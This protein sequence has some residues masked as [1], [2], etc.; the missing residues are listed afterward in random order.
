MKLLANKQQQSYEKKMT[1]IFVKKGFKIN[2]LKKKTISQ[3][4]T[5]VKI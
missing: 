2:M 1:V 3:L 5:I 4:E